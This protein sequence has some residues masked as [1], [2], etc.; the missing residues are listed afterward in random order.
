MLSTLDF[1]IYGEQRGKPKRK[2][3]NVSYMY[4]VNKNQPIRDENGKALPSDRLRL[5]L[6]E[7][8]AR[9]GIEQLKDILDKILD[10]LENA[11]EALYYFVLV[12]T[13]RLDDS[14]FAESLKQLSVD[15]NLALK[16]EGTFRA[17]PCTEPLMRENVPQIAW[18]ISKALNATLDVVDE[19]EPP[20]DLHN[21][22]PID[23]W[24]LIS[25]E[26]RKIL[27]SEELLKCVDENRSIDFFHLD[28]REAFG[29]FLLEMYRGTS[30]E[31]FQ[32]DGMNHFYLAKPTRILSESLE[33]FDESINIFQACSNL[34]ELAAG[35]SSVLYQMIHVIEEMTEYS[36]IRLNDMAFIGSRSAAMRYSRQMWS[37]LNRKM[38]QFIVK[39]L[40]EMLTSPEA[41]LFELF[42]PVDDVKDIKEP[43]I[44]QRLNPLILESSNCVD[45]ALASRV[46]DLVIGY[47]FFV[48]AK[49][50]SYKY[51]ETT[52]GKTDIQDAVELELF[53][54]TPE[55][56]KLIERVLDEHDD[57]E[58]CISTLLDVL[59]TSTLIDKYCRIVLDDSVRFFGFLKKFFTT[60]YVHLRR[61]IN[62][63][64][65]TS[66]DIDKMHNFGYDRKFLGAIGVPRDK[67]S[68]Y[69]NI[70]I[71]PNAPL[72]VYVS[73]S[74]QEIYNN[75]FSILQMLHTA[76]D[77]VLETHKSETLVHEPSLRYAFFH[78]NNTVFLIRKNM[79]GLIDVAFERMQKALD[80]R[81]RQRRP[82]TG[83]EWLNACFFA[84]R[85]FLREISD[86]IMMKINRMT[87]GVIISMM[88]ESV[89][90]ASQSCADG[91][92]VGASNHYKQFLL[93]LK[94]FLDQCRLDR[95]RYG[96]YKCLEIEDDSPDGRKSQFSSYSDDISCRNMDNYVP[97]EERVEEA[98][99][100]FPEAFH[101]C[102]VMS[103]GKNS[104]FAKLH[105]FVNRHF[106]DASNRFVM[107][108][109]I[110]GATDRVIS[111]VEVF[112]Q[113]HDGEL[114]QWTKIA[115][116]KRII[117]WKCVIDGPRDI[118]AT[119]DVP[120]LFVLL[121]KDAFPAELSCLS[122]QCS[123][124][125]DVAFR[126]H[127]PT[128]KRTP[129][130][131]Q[132]SKRGMNASQTSG[133]KWAK[134][135]PDQRRKEQA[136]RQ[137]VFDEIEKAA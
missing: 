5:L 86:A 36:P 39:K 20:N 115:S 120:V 87:T 78:M 47:R 37:R 124:D 133:S 16:F 95:A 15:Q 10:K 117:L 8:L 110:D 71:E 64:L 13:H 91:D 61:N 14:E 105:A 30:N 2:L 81:A 73:E 129:Q 65:L 21:I 11:D 75:M 79:L 123:T 72:N 32:I 137:Q 126:E 42:V 56:E 89:Q 35:H 90:K 82:K 59:P 102:P 107:F 41:E 51:D 99:N 45:E 57:L 70:S 66:I 114:Y 44:W 80:W 1:L 62:L 43:S 26:Y 101:G 3:K 100:P 85:A 22:E 104:K 103:V 108:Q 76:L 4:I 109:S 116:T 93:K 25:E 83:T 54:K 12:A 23:E 97:A 134:P 63:S 130:K 6:N 94:V 125:K 49:N 131:R 27:K 84:H 112:K 128:T 111:C 77:A 106:E 69:F 60:A 119:V 96:M 136:E 7:R 113:C 53:A 50:G 24:G 127:Q 135:T 88:V 67:R 58:G 46:V 18:D 33:I 17:R 34:Y 38:I 52:F 74:A 98:A 92:A 19:P 68:D 48:T 9:L 40:A 132:A 122:M 29:R 118:V 121:S 28:S 55:F 31:V